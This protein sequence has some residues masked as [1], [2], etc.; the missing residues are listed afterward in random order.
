LSSAQA[1]PRQSFNPGAGCGKLKLD[2]IRFFEDFDRFIKDFD[3]VFKDFVWFS[4]SFL[5][6]LTSPAT[7]T[8]CARK[9]G[10]T[11]HTPRTAGGCRVISFDFRRNR[12]VN[13]DYRLIYRRFHSVFDFFRKI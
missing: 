4:K 8:A 13:R 10:G 12:M 2:S 11:A 9:A 6:I 3:R 1:R 5:Q 7:A